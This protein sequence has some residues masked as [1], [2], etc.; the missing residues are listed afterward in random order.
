MYVFYENIFNKVWQHGAL[1][2]KMDIKWSYFL[3][4]CLRE[5]ADGDII[6]DISHETFNVN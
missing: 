6:S 5:K 3:T 2:V 1:L 4:L